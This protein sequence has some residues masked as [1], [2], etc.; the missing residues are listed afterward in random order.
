MAAVNVPIV[1]VREAVANEVKRFG[2]ASIALL[3]TK[4][5]IQGDFYSNKIESLGV[6]V[7]KPTEEETNELQK[8][9][10]EELTRGI[11]LDTSRGRFLEIARNCVAQGA[12]TVGLCCTE[13]GSLLGSVAT[14]FVSI[15]STVV[16][17]AAL[18]AA[19][20]EKST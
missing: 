20:R 19:S 11:F 10:Y 15:D 9:I 4:Y 2:K 18:L 6:R 8:I 17:V 7:V 16:H 13:F 1:D 3:G 12:Q 5:T 14:D